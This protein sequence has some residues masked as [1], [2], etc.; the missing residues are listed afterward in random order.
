MTYTQNIISLSIKLYH[1]NGIKLFGVFWM[2][3]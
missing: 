3:K 1:D 2:G